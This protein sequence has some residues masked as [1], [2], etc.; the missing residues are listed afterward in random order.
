MT[1]SASAL[2]TIGQ[3]PSFLRNAVKLMLI[4][5]QWVASVSGQTMEAI[6]PSTG[7]V[8]GRVQKGDAQDV[9][10]AVRA[11]RRAFEGDW[12]KVKPFERQSL[13]LRLADLVEANADEL[14]WLDSLDMGA[15]ISRIPRVRKRDVARLRYYAG[16]ATTIHGHTI[17]NSI[18]PGEYLSY[19]AKEPIGVVGAIIP[20]NGPMGMTIWKVGPALATGCTI[21]LKPS[22]D[23]SLSALRFAELAMEAG[24]P[25]GVINVVTGAG[26]AGAALAEHPD[27]DKIAFTG[28]TATG[29]QI[30]RA[31][32]VNVKRVSLELGGKSPDIVFDDADMEAAVP[33]AAM[34][35]FTNT[36]QLCMAG[37]RLLVQRGIYDE[38]V[39]RVAKFADTLRVGHSMDPQTQ[40]GPISSARQLEK[41]C[42]YLEV[43]KQEGAKALSGGTRLAKPGLEGGFYVAPTVFRDVDSQMRIANEEIFGPV[44]SA[45]PFDT[46]E[47]AVRVGNATP[48][49][50]A[51]GVWTR[52]VGKAHQVARRLRAGT[53]WVNCYNTLDTAVPFGGYKM[54][55]YGKESGV[56]HIDE[57]LETKAVF[58]K[59][60]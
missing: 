53:V 8:L 35:A 58:I 25:P 33:G 44:L 15:P 36:G 49:G 60:D 38:F 1:P 30:I 52:D 17:E 16:L 59:I 37:T 26:A 13:L 55:G 14:Y 46:L 11:A 23:A 57:Y 9:D 7:E 10:L 51:G 2:P 27:V 42:G 41:V 28:S 45:L 24:Y 18:T 22:E 34:A 29:Q 39:E 31:S 21:V 5:G 6:N 54:S 47:D 40:I 12:R 43:G 20:W 19:T 48:F 32:A 4:D 3:L 50:L 56:E